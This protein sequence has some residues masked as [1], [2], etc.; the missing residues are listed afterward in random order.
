MIWGIFINLCINRISLNVNKNLST[1]SK[2]IISDYPF[3][4]TETRNARK[5][6]SV[7]FDKEGQSHRV[8]PDKYD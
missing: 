8:L 6:G 3:V 4:H 5:S 1:R 2:Q 7:R